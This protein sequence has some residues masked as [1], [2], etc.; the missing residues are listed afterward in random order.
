MELL[1]AKKIMDEKL[2]DYKIM[3]LASCVDDYPMVRNV[4]CVFFNDK[5]YFKTDKYFRKTQQLFKNDKVAM[6]FNGVQVEVTAKNLGLVVDEPGRI[7]EKKYKEYLWQSYNAYSHVDSEILI[8]VTPEFV[9]IWDEDEDRKAFQ[10][11]IDF[12]K[13][14]VEYKPYD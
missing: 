5:I 2:G 7:F 1:E 3:A 13:K 10:L 11:F 12:K 14:T 8:E 9:E 4:S 6:C